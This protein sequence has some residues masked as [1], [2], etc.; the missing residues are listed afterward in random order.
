MENHAI[1]YANWYEWSQNRLC[2]VYQPVE[3]VGFAICLA[4]QL[5]ITVALTLRQRITQL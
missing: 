4:L 3:F 5:S 1:G 2:G